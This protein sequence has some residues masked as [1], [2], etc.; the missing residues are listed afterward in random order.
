MHFTPLHVHSLTDLDR[1]STLGGQTSVSSHQSSY[2]TD[3]IRRPDFIAAGQIGRSNLRI[4]GVNGKHKAAE[5]NATESDR[6]STSAT[7]S[8]FITELSIPQTRK[9]LAAAM[10]QLLSEKEAFG[11]YLGYFL[12]STHLCRMI[13]PTDRMIVLE[14]QPAFRSALLGYHSSSSSYSGSGLAKK[15]IRPEL[16]FERIDQSSIYDLFP[17]KI[18][19]VSS[20]RPAS[21]LSEGFGKY[22]QLVRL[23]TSL[24]LRHPVI[25]DKLV[26][27]IEWGT[28]WGGGSVPISLSAETGREMKPGTGRSAGIRGGDG[29]GRRKKGER[30]TITSRAGTRMEVDGFEVEQVGVL[31]KTALPKLQ[32]SMNKKRKLDEGGS[33]PQS[34]RRR[35]EDEDGGEGD[36]EERQGSGGDD[37]KGK[38]KGKGNRRSGGTGKKQGMTEA[39]A[40][41]GEAVGEAEGEGEEEEEEEERVVRVGLEKRLGL[42]PPSHIKTPIG[43][44]LMNTRKSLVDREEMRES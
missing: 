5:N 2:G 29:G 11:T 10:V 3:G 19:N 39:M 38:D 17:H 1:W 16:L 21:I 40:A 43:R 26:V 7:F 23:G 33:A 20:D 28:R 6:S 41:V 15:V 24:V 22:L 35:D 9:G 31:A 42:V 13:A 8:A 32:A 18:G 37:V 4:I 25:C 30:C 27:P 36:G 14:C 12:M 44:G 34:S